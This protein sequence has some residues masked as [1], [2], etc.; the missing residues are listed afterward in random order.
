MLG[1]RSVHGVCFHDQKFGFS[2]YP[3]VTVWTRFS[4]D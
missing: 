4:E 2:F 1:V 3:G